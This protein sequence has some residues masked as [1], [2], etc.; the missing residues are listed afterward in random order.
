MS[1]QSRTFSS[2]FKQQAPC[3]VLDQGYCHVEASR[4][5]GV[6]ESLMRRWVQQLQLKRQN[7]MPQY[8]VITPD[9]Q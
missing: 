9:P 3:L 5:I 7:I 8:K 1:K 4:S 2:E 6:G